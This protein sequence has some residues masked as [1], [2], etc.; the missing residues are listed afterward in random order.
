MATELRIRSIRERSASRATAASSSSDTQSRIADRAAGNERGH[1]I[2]IPTPGG[3]LRARVY[4]PAGTH[5]RAVLL[6]SGLHPA[7]IEEPRLV[8]LAR[9]LSASGVCVVTPDIPELSRFEI[10]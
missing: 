4:E 5:R 6:V 2:S 3:A 8:R 10:S 9:Q 7:G 1:E